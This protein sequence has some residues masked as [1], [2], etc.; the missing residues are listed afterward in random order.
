MV[1]DFL[2]IFISKICNLDDCRQ[3]MEL[4]FLIPFSHNV[5]NKK[6]KIFED[7]C[8]SG[9]DFQVG[10]RGSGQQQPQQG[11][12]HLVCTTHLHLLFTKPLN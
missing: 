6:I 3:G 12:H 8:C 11:V 1:P 10:R 5:I 7:Y 2:F 4:D 9:L